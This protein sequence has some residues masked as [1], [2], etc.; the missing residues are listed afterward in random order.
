VNPE[1]ARKYREDI[2]LYGI[3]RK[4]PQELRYTLFI[5]DLN[6]VWNPSTHSYISKGDIGIANMGEVPINKYV[7]GYI[8]IGLRSAGD[9]MNIYLEV[10]KGLWYFFN[11]RNFIMQSISSDEE[12]NTLLLEMKE[13]DRIIKDRRE[14]GDYELVISTKRKRIEFIREMEKIFGY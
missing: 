7:N 1:D 4:I 5:A 12:Y 3:G 11:Y 10:T 6:M 2:Q 13:D 9:Y 14:E 8:E